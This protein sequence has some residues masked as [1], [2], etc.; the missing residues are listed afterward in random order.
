MVGR[1]ASNELEGTC[2]EAFVAFPEVLSKT[3]KTIR[4][5]TWHRV[6][7]RDGSKKMLL[8]TYKHGSQKSSNT[9]GLYVHTYA[10]MRAS[11][12]IYEI[13]ITVNEYFH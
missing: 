4:R 10:Y 2:D 12:S 5:Y 3:T 7:I 1:T 13:C 9:A 11:A 6:G 8:V